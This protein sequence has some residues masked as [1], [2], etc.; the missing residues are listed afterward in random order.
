VLRARAFAGLR[1]ADK[2]VNEYT[3]ALDESPDDKQILLEVHRSRGFLHV[4]RGEWRQ[5]AA[6]YA[7]A[8]EL[9]PDEPYFWWYQAV[10]YL[11]TSDH[12]SYRRVCGAMLDHFGK[13]QDPRTA[14]T[15]V[16]ACTLLPDSLADMG[17]LVPVGEIAARWYPGSSRMLAAAQCRA[18]SHREAVRNFKDAARHY[19][20]RADDWLLLAL[21]HDNLDEAEQARQCYD[22]AQQWI[23]QANRR[24]LNDPAGTQPGWGDWHERIWVPL[25]RDE[26]ESHLRAS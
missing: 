2:A 25:L 18:G 9:Q 19:R 22:K 6:E 7:R 5:A 13:T 16:A 3:E 17:Q 26:I 1:W 20:L 15:V 23:H 10:L 4:S 8:G 14:H 21:A 11:A 24:Q 12:D